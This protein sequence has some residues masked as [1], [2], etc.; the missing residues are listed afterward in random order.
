MACGYNISFGYTFSDGKFSVTVNSLELTPTGTYNDKDY[1][2][3]YDNGL[4]LN[5]AIR[6]SD[7][8]G[9]WEFGYNDEGFI[10]IA[11]LNY[12]PSDCPVNPEEAFSWTILQISWLDVN[13]S[14]DEPAEIP[15][16][17]EQECFPIKVWNKQ[18]E[19]AQ[20][21]A[22]YLQAL[23]FGA[24]SSESCKKLETLKNKKRA[25]EILNCYDPR[26]IENNT[27]EYNSITYSKI[28]KLLNF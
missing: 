26:D 27:T 25:L 6:W 9:R 14:F 12:S 15:L 2:N 8:E 22:K 19:F 18:C 1:Y 13:S 10:I 28:K 5:L 20:C 21:V 24:F 16:T 11:F 7:E 4:E 17:E 3:W 23:Q